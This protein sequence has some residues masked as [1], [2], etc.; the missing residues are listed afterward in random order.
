M[1][2]LSKEFCKVALQVL[3]D[4]DAGELTLTIE[5]GSWEQ[6]YAGNVVWV[7]SNGWRIMVFNDCDDWDYIDS[8]MPPEGAFPGDRG[9][10]GWVCL[11]ADD[12]PGY[13]ERAKALEC[14]HVAK[15]RYWEPKNPENWPSYT[16]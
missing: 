4:A 12:G 15:L 1:S 16:E 5:G 13:L 2:T 9:T 7:T 6:V 14:E 11:W 3:E 10:D 8:F